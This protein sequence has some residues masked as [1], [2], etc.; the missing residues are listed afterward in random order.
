M[1]RIFGIPRRDSGA[2]DRALDDWR[3]A[4]KSPERLSG[5]A[6]QRIL[7]AVGESGER[8]VR[9]ESPAPLF[10]PVRRFALATALPLVVLGLAVGYF[11]LPGSG[12]GPAADGA[13]PLLLASRQGNEV[14]FVIANGDRPHRVTRTDDPSLPEAGE[15][16][17]VEQ[18]VFRDRL[19]S[20][21]KLVFYRID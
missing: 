9:F 12:V 13:A 14:V 8:R 18:G 5:P 17:E 21:A 11:L 3:S 15:P 16:V 20:D 4:G 6:R 10:V 2:L 19:E 7:D 1:S